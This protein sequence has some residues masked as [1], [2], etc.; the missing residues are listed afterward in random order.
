MEGTSNPWSP[1]NHLLIYVGLKGQIAPRRSEMVSSAFAG[2]ESEIG[3]RSIGRPKLRESSMPKDTE[4]PEDYSGEKLFFHQLE[5]GVRLA[6]QE[7]IHKKIPQLDR[8]SALAFAVSVARL[9]AN[10][11]E[12]AFKFCSP[13]RGTEPDESLVEDLRAKRQLFEEACAAYEALRHAIEVGYID[14]A[15][16][17]PN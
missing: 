6:N 15:R 8:D 14:I 13:H 16:I 5:Q 7:M 4:E 12:A 9:R 2:V 10:Y 17:E 11:L 1:E 3:S